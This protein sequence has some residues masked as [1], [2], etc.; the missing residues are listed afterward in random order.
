MRG[1]LGRGNSLVRL[2]VCGDIK[3]IFAFVLRF[4]RLF[5][6]G[7]LEVVYFFFVFY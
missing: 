3:F 1:M 4:V 7:E 2:V 5:L 6:R